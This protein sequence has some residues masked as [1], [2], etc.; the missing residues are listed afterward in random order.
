MR[1]IFLVIGLEE[2][3]VVG[4]SEGAKRLAI[5]GFETGCESILERN[6]AE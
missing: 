1:V 4:V 5:V 2:M 6:I 3:R